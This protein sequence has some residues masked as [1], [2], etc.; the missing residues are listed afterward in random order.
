MIVDDAL[1]L[2]FIGCH[3]Y[4]S[5]AVGR[6]RMRARV[7][8]LVEVGKYLIVAR[9]FHLQEVDFISQL[10]HLRINN[11]VRERTIS[12]QL[13]RIVGTFLVKVFLG[14]NTCLDLIL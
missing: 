5:D 9:V 6:N 13:T 14:S 3:K 1:D 2:F 8:Q 11:F 10:L 12:N 4:A 7:Q